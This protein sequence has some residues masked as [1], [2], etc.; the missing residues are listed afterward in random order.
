L[1]EVLLQ[2]LKA[3]LTDVQ[4]LRRLSSLLNKKIEF[5]VYRQKIMNAAYVSDRMRQIEDISKKPFEEVKKTAPELFTDETL[6]E[7][8]GAK[9]SPAGQNKKLEKFV[10]HAKAALGEASKKES[11]ESNLL[12]V[13]ASTSTH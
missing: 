4:H 1:E 6:L 10:E 2:E 8:E 5:S 12:P 13:I 7:F 9:N 3:R 11:D